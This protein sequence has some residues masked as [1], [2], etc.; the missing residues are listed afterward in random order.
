V[1]GGLAR[2]R[3]QA[4]IRLELAWHYFHL[5]DLPATRHA[6]GSALETDPSIEGDVSYLREWIGQ[7]ARDEHLAQEIVTLLGGASSAPLRRL[8][9]ADRLAQIA[10]DRFGLRDSRSARYAALKAIVQNPRYLVHRQTMNILLKSL[11]REMKNWFTKNQC[12]PMA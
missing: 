7:R 1:G 3:V 6:L 10:S 12:P 9:D 8:V 5:K 11:G 2:P 4:L